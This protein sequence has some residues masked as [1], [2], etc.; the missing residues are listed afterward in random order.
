MKRVILF[1]TVVLL[2]L[3]LSAGS[4]QAVHTMSWG[5]QLINN[6]NARQV[7]LNVAN[8]QEQLLEET[9]EQTGLERFQESL[10]RMVMSKA[11]RDIVYYDPESGAPGYGFIPLED[12]WIY[13]AW[14]E[15]TQTMRIFHYSDGGWTEIS[16]D[17]G[18]QPAPPSWP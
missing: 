17:A 1:G 8:A 7:A 14:D 2:I 10:E 3:G 6:P 16:I 13:Y 11:I 4:V 9:D 15:A 18:S 12:G 5:F